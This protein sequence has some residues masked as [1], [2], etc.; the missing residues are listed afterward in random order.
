M[1]DPRDPAAAAA[2]AALRR[3]ASSAPPRRR[4]P[5][6]GRPSGRDPELLGSALEHLVRDQGWTEQSAVAVLFSDWAQVVGSDLAAHVVPD[7]FEDGRLTVRAESTAWAT[8]VRL[9]LP[10]LHRAVEAAVGHGVVRSIAVA[11]P[12]APSWVSGP[13]RVKGRGPRD[14][15]G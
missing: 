9:L 3:V 8:Q 7:S 6:S 15:Y 10:G 4:R 13:R 14:T 1:T 12:A 5:P 2:A 11:G